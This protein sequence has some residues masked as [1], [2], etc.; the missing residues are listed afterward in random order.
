MSSAV[1]KETVGPKRLTRRKICSCW[2]RTARLWR[3]KR[4]SSCASAPNV[5]V[6]RIPFTPSDIASTIASDSARFFS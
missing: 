5:L 6:T 3:R 1:M 4:S 2:S